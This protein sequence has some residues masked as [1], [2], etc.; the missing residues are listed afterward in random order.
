MLFTLYLLLQAVVATQHHAHHP[1]HRSYEEMEA[2]IEKTRAVLQKR[3]D[4]ITITGAGGNGSYPRL[5]IRDLQQNADQWNLYL[6]AME[7]FKAKPRNDPMSFYQI[8]G[9]TRSRKPS[10]LLLTGIGVHGR[11]FVPWN[12]QPLLN[13]AGNCP[14]AHPLFGSWH[15]PYLAIYEQALY[16]NAAE[17]VESFPANEQ[18]KWRT[19][20]TTLRMPYFD[21]ALNVVPAVPT[22]IRDQTVTVTKPNGTVQIPN[23]LYSY[24][25]GDVLP[26]EFG[27]G[28]VNSYPETL[29][30]PVGTTSNNDEMNTMFG[31]SAVSW[32]QRLFALFASKGDWGRVSTSAY[33]V[34]TQRQNTDSFES[35]HD[36]IHG[37]VGGTDGHMTFLDVSAYDPL[38]WLHHTN[39]DRYLAMHQIL[40]NKTWV[41][42]G[43]INHPMAQ[44]NEGEMKDENSPLKPFTKNANGDYFTSMDI[45][46]TRVLGYF[47]PETEQR[48]EQQVALAVNRLYGQGEK[49]GVII[50]RSDNTTKVYPGRPFKEGDY[51]TVMSV[52]GSKYLMDGS[53]SVH[54]YLGNKPGNSSA[55]SSN[56]TAPLPTAN[57]TMPFPTANSTMPTT[58]NDTSCG[59]GPGYVGSHTFLGSQ[60]AGD[61]KNP[62]MIEGAIPLT[63]ALQEAQEKGDLKS[64]CPEDVTPYLEKNLHY[65]VIGPDGKEL[66]A[67]DIENFHVQVKSCPVTPSTGNGE[68]PSFGD[69]KEVP[70]PQLPASKPWKYEPG[71]YAL[72]SETSP[73]STQNAPWSEPGYCKV[74]QTIVYVDQEGKE[75]YREK[76]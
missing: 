12:D 35:V 15:R 39:I 3:A 71:P 76:A 22:S 67:E 74:E 58:G 27:P 31:Q 65:Q 18:E 2:H 45:R 4:K 59:Y 38:F 8:A 61:K 5:E 33:G 68:L 6:L 14:H 42:P 36:E 26:Q 7:S 63:A 1:V 23:P 47:Y 73:V 51:D 56:S 13:P 49:V 24:K 64:L 62:V 72:M 75:L 52:V 41:A 34:R 70:V 69:Y 43:R 50:K 40:T 66:C 44:W 20:L 32:R 19:V 37:T 16:L 53:Y 28:P 29:R 21:W 57:S 46:E 10:Q 9:K 30:R 11:P 60:M 25:F 55:P 17:V 54:C 48:T